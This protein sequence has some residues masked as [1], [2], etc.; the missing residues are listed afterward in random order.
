MSDLT[1][2][3]FPGSYY[4]QRALLA[5]YEKDAKFKHQV[6]FIHDGDQITP[7][8]MRMNPAGQVPV[9][10]DGKK[11]ITESDAIIKYVDENVHTGSTLVPDEIS[12]VGK[13]VA[14][15][16]KLISSVRVEIMTYG[17]LRF[18]DLSITGLHPIAK[19]MADIMKKDQGKRFAELRKTLA[20]LAEK[21]PDLRDA[22][23][24]KIEFATNFPKEFQNR[25]LVVKVLNDVEKTLDEIENILKRVKDEQ[26]ISDCWLVGPRFTAADIALATL[27]DRISFLGLT[28]RY[29]TPEKRPHLYQYYQRLGT[30]KS[31]Q[32]V[33][34]LV[35]ATP[36]MFILRK[37]KK[38]S[39]FVA[40]I[41]A[42]GIGVAVAYS[43][44]KRK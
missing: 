4:S 38:A 8:Y 1:L 41:I 9:L 17:V 27:L 29:F 6:V 42:A 43:I 10:A 16:R 2:Y 3:Y 35:L 31:V 18:Q 15:L 21:Y 19:P 34:S 23:N 36:R 5:L 28:A 7:S 14:R 32:Q 40:G 26:G 30:R 33:R 24:A 20:V 39:P 44:L 13:E 37:L 12:S 25:E 22:Y 11:I